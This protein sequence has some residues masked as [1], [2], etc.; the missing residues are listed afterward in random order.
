MR[1]A[2]EL[3]LEGQRRHPDEL[4]ADL[5]LNPRLIEAFCNLPPGLLSRPDDPFADPTLK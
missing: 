4:F 5:S 3:I 2:V 1:R